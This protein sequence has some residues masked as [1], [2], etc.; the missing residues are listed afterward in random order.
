MTAGD[1]EHDLDEV[2]QRQLAGILVRGDL[3]EEF[4]QRRA[5]EDP[6]QSD[7]GHDRGRGAVDKGVEN[8]GQDQRSL[9]GRRFESS[10]T[11][12]ITLECLRMFTGVIAKVPPERLVRGTSLD[13]ENGSS[14]V[15]ATP[16]A[17]QQFLSHLD[18][19]TRKHE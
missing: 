17:C 19:L 7:A 5:V 1:I 12:E 8:G 3:V 13:F 11:K 9:P 4:V 16:E 6:V 2:S 18:R 14:S 10:M 15:A